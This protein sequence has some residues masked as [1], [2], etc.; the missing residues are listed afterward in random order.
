MAKGNKPGHRRF[1][2]VRRLPSA[3]IRSS[4]PDRTDSG[5]MPKRPSSARATPTGRCRSSKHR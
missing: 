3:G 5:D 4:Y 2:N 1:G